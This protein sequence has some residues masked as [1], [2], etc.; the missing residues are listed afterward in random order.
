MAAPPALVRRNG[1][2]HVDLTAAPGSY[3]ISGERFAGMLY[4]DA[5]IPPVWRLKP[6]DTLKVV[7]HNRLQEPTNL[8]F[9]GLHV[10]PRGHG[11]NV[12]VHIAPGESFH[13]RIPIPHDHDSGLYWFHA[14]AHG[15]VSEQIIAGLSGAIILEGITRRYPMLRGMK[16]RVMLLKHI[17]HPRA[18]WEELVTL[19]GQLAPSI[20]IRPG[21]TQFWRSGPCRSSW[22]KAAH[23]SRSTSSA[24]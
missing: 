15:F 11:D 19:N 18:D 4:D 21:E 7:L 14:H 3:T 13:Y 6:G 12:F 17:P 16:E 5:C 8:H 23:R 20:A 24:R 1:R 9:H 22:K 10:S 2:L